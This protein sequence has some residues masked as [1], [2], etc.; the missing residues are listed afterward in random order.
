MVCSM[1]LASNG[2][3]EKFF[4]AWKAFAV[5]AQVQDQLPSPAVQQACRGTSDTNL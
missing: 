3:V 5:I 2:R 1:D 4:G